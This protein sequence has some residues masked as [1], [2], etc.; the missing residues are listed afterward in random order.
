MALT[1][2]HVTPNDGSQY[3]NAYWK[4]NRATFTIN[5]CTLHLDIYT[6]AF[7]RLANLEV[8][9]RKSVGVP[10]LTNG[11]YGKDIIKWGY[12]ELKKLPAF[13]N[14]TDNPAVLPAE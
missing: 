6:D 1:L 10:L 12:G 11:T 5:V 2:S 3:P 8:I 7:A 4:I 9:D 14:A 13:A